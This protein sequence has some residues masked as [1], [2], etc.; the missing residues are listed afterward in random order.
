MQG[1]CLLVLLSSQFSVEI[2]NIYQHSEWCHYKNNFP[3][4]MYLKIWCKNDGHVFKY[5]I[6]T[7]IHH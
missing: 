1:A 7:L 2:F 3:K 4:D 6:I 5:L